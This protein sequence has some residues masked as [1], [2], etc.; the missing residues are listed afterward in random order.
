M[1]SRSR[2]M[3]L[4]PGAEVSTHVDFNYH[5]HNRVR[6]H[7]PI[8]TDPRVTF[9]CGPESIHMG[10]G[11]CWIF[12]SW[13]RHSVVNGGS[14]P[15]V[16]LVIDTCGSSSFWE[17]VAGIESLSFEEV[18][19][20]ATFYEFDPARIVELKTEKYSS[21]KVMSPGECEYL[22]ED[23]IADF[24]ANDEN[25]PELVSRYIRLL[26]GFHQDWRV[27]WMQYGEEKE[28]LHRYQSLI[29]TVRS[30]LD[31]DMR[32]VVT[33]SNKIGVN[34]IFVQRVLRAAIAP[35]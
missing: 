25:T 11:E 4:E 13:R 29:E 33:G 9:N 24:V 26:R 8:I 31:P 12:D 10:Q 21:S 1:L 23:L 19:G 22:V 6:I 20:K 32:A 14:E 18:S 30:Q 17:M 27:H 2:L 35:L 7:I 15:R 34:P 16:H 3:R 5:W 28:H